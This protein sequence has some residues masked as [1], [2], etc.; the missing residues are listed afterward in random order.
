MLPWIEQAKSLSLAALGLVTLVVMWVGLNDLALVSRPHCETADHA[1]FAA[2]QIQGG[3]DA[4]TLES[5]PGDACVIPGYQASAVYLLP[6]GSE[7]KI[8][9]GQL[10]NSDADYILPSG[11]YAWV[12]SYGLA[13]G[14]PGAL[15]GQAAIF[16]GVLAMFAIGFLAIRNLVLD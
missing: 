10:T 9:G 5:G 7:A 13:A 15:T 1:L 2:L 8:G 4:A 16:Y 11:S 14:L 6:D 12:E 3:T